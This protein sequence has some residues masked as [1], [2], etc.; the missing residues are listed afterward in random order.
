MDNKVREEFCAKRGRPRKLDTMNEFFMFLCRIRQGFREHYL[1]HLFDVSM[2]T[3]SRIVITWSNFVYLRLGSLNIWPNRETIDRNMPESIKKNFPS[4]RVIIDCTEIKVETPSSLV[5][6][7]ELFST[8]KNHVTLKALIGCSPSGGCSFVSQLYT[9]SIS[10]VAIVKQ[11]GFLGLEF[12]EGDSIMADRGFPIAD[13]LPNGVSL[14][15]PAFLDGRSQFDQEEVIESQAIAQDRIH[16]ERFINIVK[17]FHIFD[18]VIPLTFTSSVNQL[19][20]S[21]CLLA[22][23][24]L[25]II[26][27]LPAREINFL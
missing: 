21:C 11:S 2:A 23:F 3:V 26:A 24:Q 4:T 9:G 27:S 20:T 19:F 5:F 7:S 1:A 6:V 8:C 15:I 13:C 16:I 25:G 17:D 12:D 18:G 14:N 10:D 22:N